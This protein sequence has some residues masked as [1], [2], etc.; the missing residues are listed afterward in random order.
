MSIEIIPAE[1]AWATLESNW[2][3]SARWPTLQ[4]ANRLYP[5][6]TTK[7]RANF[8]I[9]PNE[10]IFCV[11]SCFAREIERTL[12]YFGF[13]VLSMIRDLPASP[14]RKIGDDNICNKYTVASIYN[15]LRWALNPQTPYTHEQALIESPNHLLRDYQLAGP[16]YEDEANLAKR[17]RETFNHA[18][19]AIKEADVVV[20]TL[21]LSEVW[22][23]KQT[24]LYLNRPA[25]LD[26]VQQYPGRFE[27]HVFDY[28]QTSSML[29]AI[30]TLLSEHLKADFRL[31]VTVSPV[32]LL[33]TFRNQDVLLAN[34]YSKA[35]LR[36]A[37][38]EFTVNKHN[39]DYFPSYEFV[40]LSNP[41]VVWQED[42]FR[43]VNRAFVEYMM[44]SV[45]EQFVEP[46]YPAMNEAKML[47]KATVLYRG[48]FFDEARAVL[49]PFMTR[50]HVFRQPK[51]ALLWQ[52][53]QLQ[54]QGKSKT[55]LLNALTHLRY[56]DKADLWKWAMNWLRYRGHKKTI[57]TRFIGYLDLFDGQQ[58]S[59]W[60]CNREQT[61]PV[62]I[63]VFVD[64][65]L[66]SEAIANLPRTDVAEIYGKSHLNSGFHIA[67]NSQ[68]VKGQTLRV[69]ISE[70][71][72]DLIHSPVIIN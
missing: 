69:V 36:T 40:T 62:G 28:Q 60:A 11:G 37:V 39:V 24:Q 15:E 47:A 44:A 1:T 48:N 5:V 41:A 35:V 61:S 67:L 66:I 70:T 10:K 43:H 53:I 3:G 57:Q 33:S 38:E 68:V 12:R 59:G 51:F 52:A 45:M 50:E 65:Q 16:K 56:K 2:H 23:D 25:S 21:G 13:D 19:K 8:K 17:F 9:K 6:V 34:T 58:L 27:L 14:Q 29:E 26:I 7:A 72:D 42:D 30:Y 54:V 32:P 49:A 31:L 4:T 46:A 22:F 64:G 18:F 55:L 63:K 20:L 71:G